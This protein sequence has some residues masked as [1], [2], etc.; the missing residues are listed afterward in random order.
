[1]FNLQEFYLQSNK[2]E[3]TIPDVICS[4][5]NLGALD[6][7][8]NQFLGLTPSCLGYITSLRKLYLA[9]NMLDS[10][11]PTS[12]G[13]LQDLIEFNVS[14]NL[15]SGHIPP[16]FGNLKTATL[17]DLSK[18]RFSGKI[19][20]TLGGLDKLIN[21]SL[22]HNVL[23]GPIPN[24][25][26]KLLVLEFLDLCYNNLSGEILK[27]LEALVFLKYLNI[28]FNEL[29]RE[30]PT[31]GPFANVTSQS[32]LSN[33]AL[34]GE[35]WINV[36]P[37]LTKSTK[38]S[39]KRVLTS[40]Y[41]LLGIGSLLA[42]AVGYVLL[43]LRM[44][45]KNASQADVSL[46]KGHERISY[47]ELEQA[48]KGFNESNLLGN[49]S[50]SMV[51]KGILKD[52]TLFAAKVFNVRL[53]S[54]FKSFDTECEI[55]RNLRHRNVTKVITSC[56]SLNFK[57]LVLEYM[58]NG[59][60]DKWLYSYDLFFNLLQRLNIMIDVASVM[61]YL[62]NGYSTPV[63]HC[64]LKPSNILLDQEIVGHVSD[65]GT[66]KLLGAG[67]AFVQTRTI[68]TIG[69]IAPVRDA[70]KMRVNV[71]WLRT[72]LNEI[73]DA[74]N[75]ITETKKINDE[76]NRLAEQNENEKNL[77]SMKVEL[78]KLKS[79][80]ASRERQLNLETLVTEDLSNRFAFREGRS[81]S[82]KIY[83]FT[84]I[85]IQVRALNNITKGHSCL[86]AFTFFFTPPLDFIAEGTTIACPSSSANP[87][88][89]K[90]NSRS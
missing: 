46:V 74:I 49:G 35:S 1:M 54:A 7:S 87:C 18:N 63:V 81:A 83:F 72:Q 17:I 31:G 26:G 33:D 22:A 68:A 45:K 65:F 76:M 43:R 53:E 88:I 27:S 59:T 51:Y 8:E 15:L 32:F 57:A 29:N 4:L 80:I 77:E 21:L 55:F 11:L 2:I 62:H 64:D 16:E 39:R 89:S 50:F 38:K 40:L 30:I 58:P 14:S 56:S 44:T 67:E 78:E 20:S 84:Q 6:L 24:S 85:I 12:L 75:C 25:F 86:A 23:D 41:T 69:Y 66:A 42:L 19:P 13:I 71:S 70:E 3:G 5:K 73:N 28:S 60:L 34:C 61:D 82:E 36:K 79:E 10:R 37:Y 52:G 47:Y 48:T 90:K 9:Y